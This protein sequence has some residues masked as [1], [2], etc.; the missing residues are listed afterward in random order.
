VA[1]L[2]TSVLIDLLKPPAHP[3]HVAAAQLLQLRLSLGESLCTTRLCHAELLVG[4]H[5]S[6]DGT[7]EMARVRRVLS[8]L[9]V[10]EFDTRA[11]EHFG[12]IKARLMEIGRPTGDIDVLIASISIANGHSLLTR[13]PRHF[14]DIAGLQVVSY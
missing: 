2:D 6:R 7:G 5:R 3:R 13:N 1:C 11:V 14:A 12:A 9:V 8:T 10:L 4:V